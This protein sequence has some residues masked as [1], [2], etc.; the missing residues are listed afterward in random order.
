MDR[1]FDPSDGGAKLRLD[2]YAV[3][4]SPWKNSLSFKA[5]KFATVVGNWVPRHYSWDNPF[6]NAPLPYENLTGI[7]DSYAPETRR[8]CSTGDMLPDTTAVIIRTSICESRNLG[9]ELRHGVRGLRI[10]RS[11]RLCCGDKERRARSLPEYWDLTNRCFDDPTFSGRV[12]FRPNEMWDL[13]F[14][15]SGGPY[16]SP[17]PRLSL[18]AGRGIGDYR[19]FVLGQDFSFAWHHFQFWAEVFESRFEVAN[20]GDADALSYYLEAKYKITA[21][22]LRRTPLEPTALRN[23]SR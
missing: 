2:E 10:R 20:V 11:I 17:K 3:S 23:D 8:R 7:W 18:P 22:A 21:A 19:Q 1:G 5:G 15:A 13:G 12:G 16:C 4:V 14:S 6:I 9:T